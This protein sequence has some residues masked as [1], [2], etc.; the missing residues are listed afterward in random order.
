MKYKKFQGGGGFGVAGAVLG[1]IGTLGSIATNIGLAKQGKDMMEQGKSQYQAMLDELRSGKYNQTVSQPMLQAAEEQK[2]LAA[3]AAQTADQRAQAAQQAYLSGIRSGDRRMAAAAPGVI[4][5]LEAGAQQAQNQAAATQAQANQRIANLGEQYAQQNNL[6]Q[7]GLTQQEMAM[8]AQSAEAGRQ[9][10]YGALSGMFGDAQAV[11]GELLGIAGNMGWDGSISEGVN[12]NNTASKSTSGGSSAAKLTP[13][14]I[15]EAANALQFFQ[16]FGLPT[17]EK[18]MAVKKT[19]GEFSHRT[20]PIDMIA[21]D[22]TK[23]GEVTGGEYIFNPSQANRMRSML[24][25]NDRDGLFSFL[26]NL[27]N[28][29]RFKR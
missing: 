1:G 10:R 12:I 7:R 24:S 6:F 14:N 21:E 26:K 20:N 16:Q 25:Q 13:N 18:G 23:V 2:R 17:G 5:G 27:L 4:S 11:G 3:S 8:G 22:G 29:D 28:K 15:A 9:Q 19:P